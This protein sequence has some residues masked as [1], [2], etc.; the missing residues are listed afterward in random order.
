M[1]ERLRNDQ[2]WLWVRGAWEKDVRMILHRHQ[3]TSPRLRVVPIWNDR[4][5]HF[6]V[7]S[8][9]PQWPRKRMKVVTSSF[10]SF[11]HLSD[12]SSPL[13]TR[14]IANDRKVAPTPFTPFLLVAKPNNSGTTDI[15][16]FGSFH[17]RR[18]AGSRAI[19]WRL[20]DARIMKERLPRYIFRFW[21]VAAPNFVRSRAPKWHANDKRPTD[22]LR[23]VG[24]LEGSF[25]I[26]ISTVWF[27]IDSLVA[28]QRWNDHSQMWITFQYD[29]H[30]STVIP[31]SYQQNKHCTPKAM[32]QEEGGAQVSQ[33]PSVYL[34]VFVQRNTAQCSVELS[35]VA[36]IIV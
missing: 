15:I 29:A 6:D 16:V 25:S 13:N 14:R 23:R 31:V 24:V 36:P 4:S 17:H 8:F 12:L 22:Q 11:R 10:H 21:V 2:E 18:V 27:V 7:V 3:T 26:R 33:C 19:K 34:F 1:E 28:D 32:E 30:R 9:L 35:R 20:N 5:I